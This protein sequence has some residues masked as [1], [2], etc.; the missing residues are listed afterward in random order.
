MISA[1]GGTEPVSATGDPGARVVG[2]GLIGKVA[3]E[4][5]PQGSEGAG[6]VETGDWQ[7]ERQG[8]AA[9]GAARRW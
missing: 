6:P 7:T 4:Q 9:E 1:L 3:L 5:R 8:R 2:V